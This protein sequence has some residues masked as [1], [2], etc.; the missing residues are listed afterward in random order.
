M[1]DSLLIGDQ[2]SF[3]PLTKENKTMYHWA[4]Y[5]KMHIKDFKFII[6]SN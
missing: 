5:K 6:T 3:I 1:M 4:R 2:G